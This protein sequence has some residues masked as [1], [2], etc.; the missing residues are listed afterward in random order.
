MIPYFNLCSFTA[1]NSF[2][3]LP[4]NQY[5]LV[6]IIKAFLNLQQYY[7][8]KYLAILIWASGLRLNSIFRKG[9]DS[10]IYMRRSFPHLKLS[11]NHS[12]YPAGISFSFCPLYFPK[13]II[14]F[15]FM[16]QNYFT[17]LQCICKPELSH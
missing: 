13:G 10:W 5:K 9:S 8:V 4:K 14:V 17:P 6:R 1:P 12:R 3:I 15:S 11:Y 7:L 16:L 2:F